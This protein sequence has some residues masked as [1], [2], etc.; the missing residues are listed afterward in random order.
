MSLYPVSL[1]VENQLCVVIG[2]GEVAL[3]KIESLL[4]A[5]AQVKVI[6]PGESP[7]EGVQQVKRAYEKG[8][9]QGAFLV[10][11]ATNNGKVNEEVYREARELNIPVNVVDNPPL[12]TFYVPS[13]ITR[14]DLQISISTGGKYPALARELRGELEKTYGPEYGIYL[15]LLEEGR[16]KVLEN[17]TEDVRREKINELLDDR[18]ILALVRENRIDEARKRIERAIL[19]KHKD[20]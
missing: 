13:V 9:L 20:H 1:C 7:V 2:A 17:C 4:R 15:E 19:D 3:R 6:A 16:K 5:G 18:E 10:I 8:D 11:A 14:G 12:C